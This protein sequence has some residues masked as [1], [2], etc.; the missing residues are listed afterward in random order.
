MAGEIVCP[1]S[2]NTTLPFC[3][4]F[5]HQSLQKMFMISCT[6]DVDF[7]RPQRKQ[8]WQILFATIPCEMSIVIQVFFRGIFVEM[9]KCTVGRVGAIN[10]EIGFGLSGG[11]GVVKV[12][13]LARCN[14]SQG[15]F[16]CNH[17]LGFTGRLNEITG[18]G[19][20]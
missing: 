11:I 3:A 19:I 10:A 1:V 16:P 18:M 6:S 12:F 7:M 17:G 15:D 8:G 20:T 4:Q 9:I 14:L 13:A 5:P 2:D